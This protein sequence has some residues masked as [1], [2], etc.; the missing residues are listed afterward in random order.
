MF[1]TCLAFIDNISKK[2]GKMKLRTMNAKLLSGLLLIC[3]LATSGFGQTTE[4]PGC[5]SVLTFDSPDDITGMMKV[6]HD[7]KNCI[8][9]KLS[10][11]PIKS[12][13]TLE[14]DLAE[15][16]IVQI[17]IYDKQGALVRDVVKQKFSAGHVRVKFS[18]SDLPTG[19]YYI[20]LFSGKKKGIQRCVII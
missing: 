17:A 3:F 15:D 10:P 1:G 6:N 14:F 18:P 8:D 2:T 5:D 11:N 7:K 20:C 19:N 16:A 12:S 4:P 13:A 9:L